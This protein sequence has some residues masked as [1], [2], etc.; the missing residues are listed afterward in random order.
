MRLDQRGPDS[1]EQAFVRGEE[2]QR[3]T[4]EEP[5]TEEEENGTMRVQAETAK[6]C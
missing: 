3:L 1:N 2:T 4:G 5:V 6:N